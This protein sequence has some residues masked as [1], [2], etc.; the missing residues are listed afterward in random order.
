LALP[1]L[2]ISLLAGVG[3]PAGPFS[4]AVHWS[5]RASTSA[6]AE[7][8]SEARRALDQQDFRRAAELAALA[9]FRA[10]VKPESWSTL[11]LA[12]FRGGEPALAVTPFER[13]AALQ[14]HSATAHFNLASALYRSGRFAEAE[15]EY[16]AA[17]P[18]SERV[19]PL[20]LYD[21]GLAALDDDRRRRATEHFSA[22]AGAAVKAHQ[23]P[24]AERAQ[25]LADELQSSSATDEIRH[26]AGRANEALARNQLDESVARYRRALE[27]AEHHQLDAAA[28]GELHYGLGHALYRRHDALLAAR[29]F[30][31]AQALVPDDPDFCFML[32]LAQFDAGADADAAVALARALMLGLDGEHARRA[33]QILGALER[34]QRSDTARFYAEARVGVGF[35]TDVP[36]SAVVL[37]PTKTASA[38]DAAFL[39]ADLDLFWRPFGTPRTGLSLDYR[40]GQIAYLSRPLDPYSLQEHD[41]TVSGS[42]TLH[43][44]LT[45]EAGADGYLLFAGVQDFAPF[46]V[47][48][49]LGPRLVVNEEH[50]LQTRLR[51]EHVLKQSLQSVYDYL[52]GQHDE[53]GVAQ[54]W[55][56]V[57]TRVTLGY[58]FAR[59]A[60]GVEL[61]ALGDLV[62]P[63]EPRGLLDAAAVY[64]IPYS[65][66]GHEL[67]LAV[68][69]QLPRNLRLLVNTRF[70]H[71]DYTQESSIINPAGTL[72]YYL[73]SRVD[74]RLSAGF[75][76][77][78][79]FARLWELELVYTLIVN[80]STIDNTR[81]ATALDYDD[82]N[83][84]KHILQLELSL[85]Y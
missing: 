35:D 17:A 51:F 38:T 63:L 55:R 59:E 69:R 41:L 77:R 16:L 43:S 81:P 31:A 72:R 14:P 39:S 48:L 40:F 8:L 84:I 19:A 26:R 9:S 47:G 57:D 65:Y 22:A 4:G 66:L 5:R 62:L 11:G 18:L 3:D 12:R 28:L 68:A 27:L 61:V 79:A 2:L 74:N 37:T 20:A 49:G 15:R 10:P 80:R 85:V 67:Q 13:A 82:K 64:N 56:D 24:L 23:A 34:A 33:R 25:R 32:G 1:L 29:E 50:G 52:T 45:L 78:W 30:A 70:E 42:W 71:R 54:V 73:R 7:L 60:I 6:P 21:A 75:G 53:V 58:Q 44:R 36:Q 46:Q 83:Y 76:L